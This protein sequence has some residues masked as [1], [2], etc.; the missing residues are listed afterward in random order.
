MLFVGLRCLRLQCGRSKSFYSLIVSFLIFVFSGRARACAS[1]FSIV[2][3]YLD[4]CWI[5]FFPNNFAFND[6]FL[7][8]I[9]FFIRHFRILI[10][11]P[12]L[13]GAFSVSRYPGHP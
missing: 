3:V 7:V 10:E 8:L 6:F 9:F 13:G 4:V 1:G 2:V 11:S 5:F 12:A